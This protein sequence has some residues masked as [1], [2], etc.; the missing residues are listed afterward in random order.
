[1]LIYKQSVLMT[2]RPLAGRVAL[3]AGATRGAGRGIAIELGVAGAIV[4]CT[5]R[6]SRL[7]AERVHGHRSDPFDLAKRPETIEE[8]AELVTA[9]GGVGIPACVD[10][11]DRQAVASLMSR[12]AAE[13]RRLDI[14]VNDIWGGDALTDWGKAFWELDPGKGKKLFDRAVW[15]HITTSR[16][17][18]PLVIESRR[19]AGGVPLVVEVTDG[20]AMYYRGNFF[21]DLAKT[22]VIR[23]AFAMSE[24]LRAHG[25]AAVAVTPG[26]LRSEAMLEHFGVTT[27]SWRKGASKD[28][29]FAYSETPRYIGRGVAALSADTALMS[30]TGRLFSSWELAEHYGIEDVDGS[31]PNWG[32]LARQATFGR[33]Q[34]ESHRRFVEGVHDG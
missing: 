20:D 31:R 33:D 11:E 29:N 28:P 30:K 4:Y 9:A 22:A 24:E 21:Y 10:H 25:V 17:A 23:L 18:V 12:I 19:A 34:A 13:Q 32:A 8:T 1:M 16:C 15:T 26:F 14:V 6:S 27:E 5:G 7:H 2:E 3:V